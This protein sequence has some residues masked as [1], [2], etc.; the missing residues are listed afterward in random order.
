MPA[1]VTFTAAFFIDHGRLAALG[2]QV[3]DLKEGRLLQDVNLALGVV[4]TITPGVEGVTPAVKGVAITIPVTPAIQGYA[5]IFR[6]RFRAGVG[7]V[8]DT[9]FEAFGALFDVIF[10]RLG[11]AVGQGAHA[12]GAKAQRASAAD[13]G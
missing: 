6:E 12:V 9:L 4:I 5:P 2:A 10:Q 13:A 11:H 3:A 8:D 7:G 1:G